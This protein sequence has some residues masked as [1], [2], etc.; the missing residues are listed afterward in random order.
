MFQLCRLIPNANTIGNA[1]NTKRNTNA[2]A[3]NRYPVRIC[4]WSN[5]SLTR[6]S[7]GTMPYA[8]SGSYPFIRSAMMA[9]PSWTTLS[10]AVC[11]SVSP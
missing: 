4:R 7:S 11:G 8:A 1:P 5:L 9:S 2:G 3:T 10:I 6:P